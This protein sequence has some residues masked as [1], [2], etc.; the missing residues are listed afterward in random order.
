MSNP[1]LS[2]K[3]Y[4]QFII[5]YLHENNGYIVHTDADYNRAYSFDNSLLISFLYA[6]QKKTM[7]ELEKIY[8]D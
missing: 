2:E 4:Q 8:K 1:I 6:T 3:Q 5:D 7:Q